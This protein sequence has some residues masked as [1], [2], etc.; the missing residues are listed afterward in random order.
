[1]ACGP[2]P[3]AGR[4][5]L[6]LPNGLTAQAGDDPAG[7]PLHYDL[8]GNGFASWD[9]T[10]RAADST[11][12]GRYFVAARIRDGL[13][14]VLEDVALVTIGE[15]GGVDTSLP[16]EELFSRLQ[17]DVQALT[18]EAD[19]E[20][21]TRE[22]RL[23]PGQRGELVVRVISRLASP[24]R[25]EAQLISPIGTW[26][27]T[28]PWTQAVET[29]AGGQAEVRFSVTVPMTAEPGWQSWLLVKFMY[30]G[31]VRYSKAV[32]LIVG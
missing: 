6:S 9:L 15:P 20:V 12:A 10:V 23:A 32:P 4:V 18:G 16:P 11:P 24:L 5:E 30:F 22:L 1:V 25:G 14:Q 2:E 21:L 27:A 13:G 26:Q 7:T 28:A 17:S 19:V 31:R 8:P 3:A 29:D